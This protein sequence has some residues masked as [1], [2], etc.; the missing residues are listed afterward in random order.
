MFN[1]QKE[2]QNPMFEK[3]ETVL[4]RQFWLINNFKDE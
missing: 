3:L 4:K 1:I 2:L